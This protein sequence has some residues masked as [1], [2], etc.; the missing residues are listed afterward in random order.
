MKKNKA[1]FE[2]YSKTLHARC[3]SNA[4][5]NLPMKRVI[6]FMLLLA[7]VLCL[8]N[9]KK[10]EPATI[11][12]I[13]QSYQGGFIFYI[14]KVGDAGYDSNV[15]H[16]I[17][18][19]PLDQSAGISW[20]NGSYINIGVTADGIGSGMANTIAIVNAQG[21]GNY[22]AKICYDLVLGGYSDWYL[23]SKAECGAMYFNLNVFR[24]IGNFADN[25]TR[26]WSSTEATYNLVYSQYGNDGYGPT[27]GYYKDES[28]HVRAVRS[29]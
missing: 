20:S 2:F 15:Q 21:E 4:L 1:D 14:L 29:F 24:N 23:P 7:C 17:I 12:K 22:A 26:Y 8:S 16:G 27:G 19:A 25:P 11:L 18:A 3:S 13:G 5:I 9:C 6:N 28:S 10:D